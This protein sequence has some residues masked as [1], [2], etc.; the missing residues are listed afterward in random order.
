MAKHPYFV[1]N[2]DVLKSY[3]F[4]RAGFAKFKTDVE[5]T[6]CCGL[7]ACYAKEYA[8][9]LANAMHLALTRDGVR[10]GVWLR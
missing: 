9:D 4:D 5:N 7:C 2:T 1:N 3:E 6:E 8:T 10:Y